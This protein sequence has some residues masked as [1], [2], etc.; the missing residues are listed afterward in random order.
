MPAAA[1]R[2]APIRPTLIGSNIAGLM[3]PDVFFQPGMLLCNY[4]IS[5]G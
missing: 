1:A 2:P 4:R 3:R 5:R